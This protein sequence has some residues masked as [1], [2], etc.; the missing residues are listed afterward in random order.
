LDNQIKNQEISIT[1]DMQNI[2]TVLRTF[3]EKARFA[4]ELINRLREEKRVLQED[5]SKL[6]DELQKVKAELTN[7]EQEVKRLRAEQE[8]ML[9][10]M[11]GNIFSSQE[12]EE[13]KSKIKDLILKINSHL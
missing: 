3:W 1:E 8:Q 12:K 5:C 11:S 6:L 2:E 7:K 13:L 4:S 10:S 9:S